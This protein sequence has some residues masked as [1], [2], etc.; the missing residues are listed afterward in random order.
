[1]FTFYYTIIP[2]CEYND[3]LNGITNVPGTVSE[4]SKFEGSKTPFRAEEI[5]PGRW[6][7]LF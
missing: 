1:M 6:S 7:W 2:S 3:V 4:S 5:F